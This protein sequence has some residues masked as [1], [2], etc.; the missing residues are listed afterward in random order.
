VPENIEIK[1]ANMSNSSKV[2][3]DHPAGNRSG[4]LS[5]DQIKQNF[6]DMH[7]PLAA[8]QAYIEACR[9]YFCFDAPC[10][11]AC[12]TD[13][14]IPEFIKRIQCGNLKGSAHQ[15]LAQ[16]IMGGM[17]ARVCP[18][19][20]LCEQACVR[21]THEEKPVAIGLLQRYATDVVIEKKVPLFERRPD[22]GKRVAV[23]G[24]GPAG[25][26]CAHRL[27][28]FGH[29]ITVF[30]KNEKAGGLN[31]YGIAAYKVLDDIAQ[32]EIDYIL[33]IG[34]IEIKNNSELGADLTLD[35]LRDEFDAVFIGVG[36]AG[37]NPHEIPG[38]AA[39]GVAD[40]VDYI[41]DLRQAA[42]KSDLPV[43]DKV[44]VV[45]G[46]MTAI[47]IA[48]QSKKLGASEVTIAYRRDQANMK[49]SEYEQHYAQINDVKLRFCSSPKQILSE[50]GRVTGIEFDI[51]KIDSNGNATKTGKTY[52]L[53]ADVMFKA[54][55]QTLLAEQLGEPAGGLS[56]AD[57]R[58]AVNDERKTSLDN[59]W[60]GGDCVAGGEDLTVCAVQDGKLAAE[61]IHS[62]LQS[63]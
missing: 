15:I 4:R 26:S 44:V 54:I 60:A 23:V 18:T 47:D 50:D 13:I 49:A 51:T 34:G 16:N 12:P 2:S 21:N 24:A 3:K 5:E 56:I 39:D 9:C 36:L 10:T 19:E 37:V 55:G 17:C 22:T 43:G 32:K 35:Q 45:G 42:R 59:V 31:E 61:S 11:A 46:G 58:I 53:E 62:Y 7:P 25:L 28:T 30:D 6:A 29:R 63:A 40:A 52:R 27:A 41:A 33:E 57:G 8:S 20:E 14:D 38:E 1:E 48:V